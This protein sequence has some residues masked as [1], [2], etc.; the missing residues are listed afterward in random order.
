MYPE[1]AGGRIAVSAFIKEFNLA[2]YSVHLES[3]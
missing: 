3:G 1:R 2:V